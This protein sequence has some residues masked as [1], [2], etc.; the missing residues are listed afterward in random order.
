MTNVVCRQRVWDR[1][2]RVARESGALVVL[3]KVERAQGVTNIVAEQLWRLPLAA[4]TAS[5]DFR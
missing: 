2:R 5:R 3:G 1:N 4:R